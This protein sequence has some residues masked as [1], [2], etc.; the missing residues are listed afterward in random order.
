[1]KLLSVFQNLSTQEFSELRGFEN[2]LSGQIS[3]NQ[4][5]DPHSRLQECSEKAGLAVLLWLLFW[6]R[7]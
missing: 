1:M 7:A 6:G 2:M 3:I 5:V 4:G